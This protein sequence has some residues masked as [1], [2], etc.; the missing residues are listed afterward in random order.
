MDHLCCFFVLFYNWKCVFNLKK[1]NNVYSQTPVTLIYSTQ[2]SFKLPNIDK[3]EKQT[4]QPHFCCTKHLNLILLFYVM[5][6][7]FFFTN[8]YFISANN[9]YKVI[10]S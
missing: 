6:I 3:G 7:L 9:V 1:N 10:F 4:N 8:L 2:F 5:N